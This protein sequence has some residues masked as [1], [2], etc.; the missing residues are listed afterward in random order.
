MDKRLREIQQ[1]I[2][3]EHKD[4][5]KFVQHVLDEFDKK[6]DEHRRLSSSN[7]L[8]GI[9][10]SGIAEKAFYDTV[11]ETKKW[12]LDVLERTIQDFEHSGDKHW[13]KNFKDGVRE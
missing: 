13:N 8:A 1:R 6:A 7:A 2:T 10:T 4:L 5:G 11:T 3:Q 12:I 9:K